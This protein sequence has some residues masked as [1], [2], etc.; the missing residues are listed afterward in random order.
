[1][2]VLVSIRKSGQSSVVSPHG[3]LD[4]A[5]AELGGVAPDAVGC[6]FILRLRDAGDRR[7][8]RAVVVE[9]LLFKV[10]EEGGE[11]V[12]I[13]LRRRIIFVIVTN[14][15]TYRETHEGSAECFR[16]PARDV[17]AQLFGDGSAFI[18]PHPE[19]NI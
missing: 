18:A 6:G 7:P 19:T 5:M 8:H 9:G 12:E 4:F 17:G 11:R 2:R 14:G 10:V 1:M 15:A 16:A 3:G 13:L